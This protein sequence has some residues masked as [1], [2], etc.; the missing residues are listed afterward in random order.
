MV[1]RA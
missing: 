1:R